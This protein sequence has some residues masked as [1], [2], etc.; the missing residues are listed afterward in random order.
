MKFINTLFL[1]LLISTI[2]TY[3]NAEETYIGDVS[4]GAVEHSAAFTQM[5]RMLGEWKGKLYQQS[6]AVVDT[7]SK[8]RLVSNGNSIVET[9]IEDGVEMFTTYS[10]KDGKLVI[11]HYCALG[12]EPMFTVASMD[13]NSIQLKSDPRPGYHP[14]H[15]N[16][17]KTMG[18]TFNDENE[19]RVDATLHLDGE[20][21]VQ[22]SKIKRIN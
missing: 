7:Y 13:K 18:W 15:H 11:K 8:F 5:K 21:Q 17:V 14:E 10:D 16:Y 19:V 1:S 2:S 22:H 20:L 6:G 9:L 3:T 12:T 4:M